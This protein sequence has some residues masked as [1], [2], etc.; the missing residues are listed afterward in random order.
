MI[1]PGTAQ[2]RHTRPVQVAVPADLAGSDADELHAWLT[3]AGVDVADIPGLP[4]WNDERTTVTGAQH[5][6]LP[7]D[8]A[9]RVDQLMD[10]AFG[11]AITV[12]SGPVVLCRYVSRLCEDAWKTS[13][14]FDRM[15]ATLRGA[16]RAWHRHRAAVADPAERAAGDA[17]AILLDVLDWEI[18]V[19]NEMLCNNHERSAYAARRAVDHAVKAM[20]AAGEL[21]SGQS[22]VAAFVVAAAAGSVTF[23]SA[24]ARAGDGLAAFFADTT[25]PR[26]AAPRSTAAP[27]PRST[28]TADTGLEAALAALTRAGAS[29]DCDR[30]QRSELR[31][32]R[33]TVEALRRD[34]G[35]DWLYVDDGTVIHMYPFAVRGTS[36]HD[37]VDAVRRDA[38]GWRLTGVAPAAVHRTL[39]LDDIWNGSDA[40][41]RRYEGAALVLPEVTI[42]DLDGRPLGRLTA[43]LRLS[44]LG[45]HH[46]RLATD[47]RD[48][49]ADDLYGAMLRAAPEHGE[50]RV[51][52]GDSPRVWSRL[53]AFAVDIVEEVG[54]LL[55]GPAAVSVRPGM[56]HVLVTVLEASLG[57]GPRV[58]RE[59]RRPVRDVG[60]LLAAVGGQVLRHP[61]PNIIGAPAEW[62]RFSTPGDVLVDIDRRAD[63]MVSRTCNTT[64]VAALGSPAYWIATRLTVAEF[65][66]SLEGLFAGW[67][68][69]LAIFLGGATRQARPTSAEDDDDDDVEALMRQAR[70]LEQ[71]QIRLYAFAA[72]ARSTLDLI[73]SPALVASPLVNRTLRAHLEVTGFD[74]REA[75]L[76][77]NIE[78]VLD[79]R[80]GRRLETLVSRRRE[81][82]AELAQ[83]GE[84]RQ[85]ARLDTMLAVIAAVGVSGLGQIYQAGYDI[86]QARA[87]YIIGG[88]VVIMFVVGAWFHL[89]GS[90]GAA[91]RSRRAR[92]AAPPAPGDSPPTTRSRAFRDT[93][94]GNQA[95]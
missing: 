93:R 25:A 15:W 8:L 16:G 83:A 41:G 1:Q 48:A 46:L 50:V 72:D 54:R 56:F 71:Q 79:D 42:E 45:N 13:Y 51:R 19:E 18:T 84:R 2:A 89:Y 62:I 33:S 14:H 95:L 26:A 49:S 28:A 32:Y 35:R 47:L 78:A 39:P 40:L 53:S 64:L 63:E 90:S 55:G 75:E 29:A 67:S 82:E 31:A 87:L 59:H 12:P 43:E 52:C 94:P 3:T 61:V 80:L 38:H 81:R 36:P 70:V 60:Q 24:L 27:A 44:L 7:P 77:R 37:V 85:R 5:R 17:M 92:A 76:I 58:G 73:R 9:E 74:R 68:D 6:R 11:Q 10:R 22:A 23:D 21:G 66:A 30:D 4:H 88:I 65:V 86:R 34:A 69:E 91:R 57:A 20:S